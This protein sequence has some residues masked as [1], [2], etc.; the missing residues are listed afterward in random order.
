MRIWEFELDREAVL[1]GPQTW[2]GAKAVDDSTLVAGGNAVYLIDRRTGAVVKELPINVPSVIHVNASPDGKYVVGG[3]AHK[4]I[5]WERDTGDEVATFDVST[6]VNPY[7]PGSSFHSEGRYFAAGLG[8]VVTIWNFETAS[9]TTVSHPLSVWGIAFAPNGDLYAADVS[10]QVT[11]FE[12]GSWKTRSG[13]SASESPITRMTVSSDGKTLVTCGHDST[14]RLWSTSTNELLREIQVT[15]GLSF[16]DVAIHPDGRWLATATTG[17][18]GVQLWELESG[19]LLQSFDPHGENI[20]AVSFSPNGQFVVGG[21]VR[22]AALVYSVHPRTARDNDLAGALSDYEIQGRRVVF[23]PVTNLFERRQT[24]FE[25][26][27]PDTHLALLSRLASAEESERPSIQKQLFDCFLTTENLHAAHVS[28]DQLAESDRPR[29]TAQLADVLLVEADEV[30]EFGQTELALQRITLA[31]SISRTPF[32]AARSR[33]RVFEQSGRM[34]EAVAVLEQSI[35]D[36]RRDE[37]WPD[38]R[39]SMR[40]RLAIAVRDGEPQDA[41]KWFQELLTLPEAKAELEGRSYAQLLESRLLEGGAENEDERRMLLALTLGALYASFA[42]YEE[43]SIGSLHM[44]QELLKHEDRAAATRVLLPFDATWRVRDDEEAPEDN[45]F[46]LGYDDSAW[47]TGSGPFGFGDSR[48]KTR[49]RPGNLVYYAR[50]EFDVADVESLSSGLVLE[51]ARDD[52]VV[53]Y[54]NGVEVHRDNLPTNVGVGHTTQAILVASSGEE[55]LRR[56][57]DIPSLVPALRPGKNVLAVS[58][59]Q[60]KRLS[61]DV[62][63]EAEL[64]VELTPAGFLG[65]LSQDGVESALTAAAEYFPPAVLG[66]AATS[67]RFMLDP[68]P[69]TD[70]EIAQDPLEWR[71]SARYARL[72]GRAEA[73]TAA[74]EKAKELIDAQP[75]ADSQLAVSIDDELRRYLEKSRRL[76]LVRAL[77]EKWAK[78]TMSR[79]GALRINVG[80]GPLC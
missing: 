9:A 64:R 29:A 51:Y 30:L 37:A 55:T 49:F 79:T 47:R 2:F 46:E 58:I 72:L 68:T 17:S 26:R 70:Q 21:T 20:F 53:F 77:D 34:D 13:W 35:L 44:V 43:V 12:A 38:A 23:R 1:R 63:F 42:N 45:W 60:Q 40:Q 56:R 33:A 73:A 74:Y 78:Q 3:N 61:S 18:S 71:R 59:H 75:D 27:Q 39:V 67:I 8:R 31:E 16:Q 41:R 11:V 32:A 48:E 7:N 10:G 5:L 19:R 36:A 62:H 80:G 6:A 52:G 24:P 76:D 14:V 4:L 15:Q 28:L 69:L 25:V 66:P 54:L 57:P 50:T 65:R 22:G